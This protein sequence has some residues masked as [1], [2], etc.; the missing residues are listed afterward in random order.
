MLIA[1]DRLGTIGGVQMSTQYVVCRADQL[2]KDDLVLEPWSG[3][4]A[5][6]QQV[7]QLTTGL[8]RLKIYMLVGLSASTLE[9]DPKRLMRR[10]PRRSEKTPVG[11]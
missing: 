9:I 4:L 10:Q 8:R 11:S 7:E 2:Q 5:R 3:A 1:G 6:V